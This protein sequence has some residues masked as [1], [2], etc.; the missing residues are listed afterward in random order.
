L[1]L[2]V[3]Q[4]GLRLIQINILVPAL[5]SDNNI[6]FVDIESGRDVNWVVLRSLFISIVLSD[7]VKVISSDDDGSVHLG[8]DDNTPFA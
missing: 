7:V 5:A 6:T 1:N 4:R 8:G 2:T 3:L